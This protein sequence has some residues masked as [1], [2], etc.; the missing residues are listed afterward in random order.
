MTS[1]KPARIALRLSEEQN[2]VIRQAADAEGV[3]I[4]EFGVAAMIDRAKD[5]LS[6]QRVFYLNDEQWDAF[7]EILDKPAAANPNLVKLLSGPSM[8]SDEEE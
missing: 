4:T 3:S 7:L 5:V 2:A 6:D 1:L 8:F